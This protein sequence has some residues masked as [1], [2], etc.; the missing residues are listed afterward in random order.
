MGN[1]NRA[2]K[3]LYNIKDTTSQIWAISE[4]NLKLHLRIKSAIILNLISPIIGIIMPIIVMGQLFTYSVTFGPWDETNFFIFQVV[5][6]QLTNIFGI[7][8]AFPGA[9][10]QEKVW[11]TLPALIIAPFKRVNLL[12]GIFVS[13]IITILGQFTFFFILG[14]VYYPISIF[15][16]ISILFVYFLIALIFSGIGLVLGIGAISKENYVPI[17]KFL[18]SI[19]F[20]F[21]CATLP[22]E[23]YPEYLAPV[24]RLNPMYYIIDFPRLVWIE[25]N[26]VLSILSHPFRFSLILGLAILGPLVG[27]MLFNYI[28]NKYGIQGY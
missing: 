24:I 25:D 2:G 26:F 7:M 16:I 28:F 15:T 27:L 11:Q 9:L 17:L 21:S 4:K 22:F 18:I 8:Y 20:L 14:L 13:H 3:L 5:A 6:Y 1:K 10:S 19:L 23:F 12:I